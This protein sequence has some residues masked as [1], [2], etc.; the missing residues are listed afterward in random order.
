MKYLKSTVFGGLILF[1]TLSSLPQSRGQSND[2]EA[3]AELRIST[4]KSE[5]LLGE[6]VR[7]ERLLVKIGDPDRV[8]FPDGDLRGSL[9]VF[10]AKGD[11]EFRQYEW[12]GYF[13]DREYTDGPGRLKVFRTI[14]FNKKPVT[15]HLSDYG[16]R[17]AEKGMILTDYAFPEPGD[18][19]IKATRGY[20]VRR[21]TDRYASSA[22]AASNEITIRIKE[23]EGDDLRVWQIMKA[24]TRIG[25]FMTDG[26]APT[27]YPWTS[28][29]IHDRSLQTERVLQEVDRITSDYPDSY[30]AG[31]LKVKAQEHRARRERLRQENEQERLKKEKA[32]SASRKN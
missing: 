18:Y 11:D 7:L 29:D 13:P 31:L 21:G 8:G 1:V 2:S 3:S 25:F 17:I 30:L 19:R 10:I 9:R 24:D 26:E 32:I 6:P 27:G 12:G 14:F 4:T 28:G 23:P 22:V 20:A 5:Y 15:Y 16:R